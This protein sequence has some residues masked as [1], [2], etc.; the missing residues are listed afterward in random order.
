MPLN[1]RIAKT[2]AS[3]GYHA[4][5]ARYCLRHDLRDNARWHGQQARA[6]WRALCHLTGQ[7]VPA[8]HRTADSFAA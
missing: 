6:D 7:P 1:I 2:A 4:S 3:Y 5:E 8:A